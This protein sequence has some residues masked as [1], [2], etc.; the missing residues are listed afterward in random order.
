MAGF[1]RQFGGGV[2]DFVMQLIARAARGAPAPTV[3]GVMASVPSTRGGIAEGPNRH[4][5]RPSLPRPRRAWNSPRSHR[6][7][8]V[9]TMR[10]AYRDCRIRSLRNAHAAGLTAL[11]PP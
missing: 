8:L 2:E 11:A 6:Y 9:W 1:H 4:A 10:R 3:V 7:F 5:N